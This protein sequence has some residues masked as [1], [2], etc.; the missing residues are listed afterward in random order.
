MN[1][2]NSADTSTGSPRSG[3]QGMVPCTGPGPFRKLVKMDDII[4]KM[5]DVTHF[6]EGYF[7][8]GCQ[9]ILIS[10]FLAKFGE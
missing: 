4:K 7:Y 10:Y 6:M 3:V 9:F 1:T 2:S 5:G 8:M